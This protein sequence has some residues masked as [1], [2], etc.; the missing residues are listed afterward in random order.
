MSG[1]Q[2][3]LVISIVVIVVIAAVL[4]GVVVRNKRAFSAGHTELVL[5]WD[6]AASE[7]GLS[8]VVPKDN[9]LREER[10]P[11]LNGRVDG[12][13]VYLALRDDA[14]D[15]D[16]LPKW[17]V[18]VHVS[19]KVQGQPDKAVLKPLR[20]G[21]R[22]TADVVGKELRVQRAGLMSDPSELVAYVREVL[23]AAG[24]LESS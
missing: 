1:Q 2:L 12:R 18:D 21:R 24:R 16:L 6:A 22:A 9:V 10:P 3:N 7:L 4:I 11:A 20:R 19:C 5:A 8:W 13:T 15:E 14:V 17:V 23:D